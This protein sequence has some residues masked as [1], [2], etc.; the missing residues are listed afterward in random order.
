MLSTGFRGFAQNRN[1]GSR[2]NT[3]L[4]WAAA[5]ILGASIVDLII[6]GVYDNKIRRAPIFDPKPSN[7]ELFMYSPFIPMISICLSLFLLVMHTCH[8]GLSPKASIAIAGLTLIGYITIASIWIDCEITGPYVNESGSASWCP[9]YG[10]GGVYPAKH[11][12]SADVG[13]GAGVGKMAAGWVC[14]AGWGAY[15]G[16]TVYG[17]VTKKKQLGNYTATEA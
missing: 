7:G 17:V 6:A 4:Q 14:V 11:G 2:L 15:L 13:Y 8:N 9:Q 3:F 16:I 5:F 1:N 12:D 10:L